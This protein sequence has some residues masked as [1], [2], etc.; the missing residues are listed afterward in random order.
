[1]SE[2]LEGTPLSAAHIG[3]DG[4]TRAKK[5]LGLDGATPLELDPALAVAA[6]G[7]ITVAAVPNVG[8]NVVISDGLRTVTFPFFN[9]AGS[10]NVN[11]KV[12]VGGGPSV[13]TVATR[14]ADA[15][16]RYLNIKVTQ[17]AGVLTLVNKRK[18]TFGNA[19]ITSSS[20]GLLVSGMSGGVGS[21]R[22]EPVNNGGVQIAM[23]SMGQH[24]TL[25]DTFTI[26]SDV[27]EFQA[28]AGS[29]A[30]DGH[31]AVLRGADAA[32]DRANAIAAINGTDT[33]NSHASIFQTDGETPA[34]SRGTEHFF[35]DEV[36]TSIRIRSAAAVGSQEIVGSLKSVT[37][38]ESL[39]HASNV[40]DVG[41]VDLN[42]L[43]G[44]APMAAGGA[45]VS[46]TI[47]AAMVTAGAVRFAFPFPVV[48]CIVQ[49]R[50]AAGLLR[51]P[52]A[53]DAVSIDNGDVKIT[54]TSTDASDID[55]TDIVTVLA[56]PG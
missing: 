34:L 23:L 25:A 21:A 41:N 35:A 49:V 18:G 54:V 5:L 46:R 29:L 8:T 30:A 38:A 51:G 52:M 39:T 15:I 43:G 44:S 33:D 20:T 48:H 56:F 7:R 12:D 11:I 27:Y 10:G 19:A 6:S 3:V 37:L 24:V 45:I 42:T 16:R 26:G 32:A 36:G 4:N 50:T 9:N 22:L 47:T 13:K 40:W 17:A 1:M 53:T 28:A 31:I 2:S 14:L 55:A